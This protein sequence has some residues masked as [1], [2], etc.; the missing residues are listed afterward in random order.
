MNLLNRLHYQTILM[1][2]VQAQPVMMSNIHLLLSFKWFGKL[3]IRS[4]E[5]ACSQ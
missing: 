4:F 3:M 1:V 2:D 5:L